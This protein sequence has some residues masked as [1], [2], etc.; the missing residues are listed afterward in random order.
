[1]KPIVPSGRVVGLD[2]ARCLALVGMM[3]TH[4]LDP[5]GADG[6]TTIQYVAG[7]RSSAL[8]AVLAG[9]SLALMTGRTTPLTGRPRLAA[10]AGLAVRALLVAAIGLLLGEL[11]TGI[12]VIL[13]YYGLLFLLGLPFLGLRART[14]A[15][16][17]AVWML[18]VPVLSHLLRPRLPSPSY[19]VPVVGSLADPWQLLTELA[20]TGY[21]PGVVWL[22]YLLAGMAVGR[23]A[24]DGA[25]TTWRLVV[26]G[27]ALTVAAPVVSEALLDRPGVLRALR[28]TFTGPGEQV[29]M[30]LTLDRGLYGT[31]PTGSWWW[32][33]VDTP[34]T[35][36][37]LDLAGTTGSALLVVGVCL[38]AVR[39][40]PEPAAVVFGA[41]A[42]TLS[43]YSLHVVLRGPGFLPEPGM[44]TYL[45]H[46]AIVLVLGAV[47]RLARIRGPL[48]R[49]VGAAADG[50][51]HRFR[52]SATPG[53]TTNP[54]AWTRA[55]WAQERPR[56]RWPRA[57]T[58]R[59]PARRCPG[60]SG[61]RP[62]ARGAASDPPRCRGRW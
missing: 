7:G 34:H 36:T 46:V 11:E 17:S 27:A 12:A 62:R 57:G 20:F 22:T 59:S 61:P 25:G 5:V 23:V 28:A 15:T 56:R 9:V 10:S 2:V 41:G 43:L 40:A 19:E 21:Y 55:A 35:A 18:V 1:M 47:Y 32:L 45:L 13:T 6:V 52:D 16:L 37:P 50:T 53:P 48:E 33:A 58:R 8:F 44:A 60:R 14:L 30:A 31:T 24:L 29:T 3:A 39:R 4:V 42:M 26:P 49:A 54:G 38:A 51:R